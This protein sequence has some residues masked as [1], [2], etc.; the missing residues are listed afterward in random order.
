MK[1]PV[2]TLYCKQSLKCGEGPVWDSRTAQL[3]WTDSLGQEIYCLSP[4]APGYA[5]YNKGRHAASLTMHHDGGLMCCGSDG[6]FHISTN[7]VIRE[8]N[9]DVGQVAVDHLNDI[10]ADPA[11]RVFSGQ[12]TYKEQEEYEPG[13][14]FRLDPGGEISIVDE[15]LHLANGMGFSPQADR[16]YL[17]DTVQRCIYSY[18]YSVQ[19]GAISNKKIFVRIPK[20]EGLPD[21]LAVDAEGFIWVARWFGNGLSRYDPDGVLERK[22]YVP[23]AQTSSLT[24]GGEAMDQIFIT[25]A[26]V[27]WTSVLAPHQHNYSSHRGGELYRLLHDIQGKPVFPALV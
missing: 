22:V 17:A 1:S 9:R 13:Y 23:A 19:S 6:F 18:D 25:S 8:F 26:A 5:L 4:E 12:E 10:I 11:G 3:Y 7:G 27:N 2:A 16:F 14:L 20:E 15:G 21:G 24:F